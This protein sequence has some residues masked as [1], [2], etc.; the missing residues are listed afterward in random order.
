M[1]YWVRPA[2][3]CLHYLGFSRGGHCLPD[4]PEA[5][6]LFAPRRHIAA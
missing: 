1:R 2:S 5:D 4:A 3:N 6:A